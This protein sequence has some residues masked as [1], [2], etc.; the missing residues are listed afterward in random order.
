M[1]ADKKEIINSF[2]TLINALKEKSLYNGS[3]ELNGNKKHS[4]SYIEGA[5]DAY[6][7]VMDEIVSHIEQD[8]YLTLQQ[9]GLE[10]F[11]LNSILDIVPND[12][13]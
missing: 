5:Q 7:H 3:F 11:D 4:K 12:D 8:E 9:F 6:F 1:S 13:A 10:D 2:S